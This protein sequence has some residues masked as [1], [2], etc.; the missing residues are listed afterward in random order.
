MGF[1]GLPGGWELIVIVLAILL[2][3]G[4]KRIPEIAHGIGKAIT[5]FKRGARSTV[6]E[7]KKEIDRPVDGPDNGDSKDKPR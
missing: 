5:E 4:A 7:V 1:V 2:L 6:D 3:F